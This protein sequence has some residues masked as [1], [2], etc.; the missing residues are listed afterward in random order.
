MNTM[1]NKVASHRI[2]LRKGCLE[3]SVG[4]S[5]REE[6]KVVVAVAVVEGS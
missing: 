3:K 5:L 4:R 1:Q 2:E 6:E